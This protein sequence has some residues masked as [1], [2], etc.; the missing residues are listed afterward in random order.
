MSPSGT[1]AR[2]LRSSCDKCHQTK[3]KCIPGQTGCQRCTNLSLHCVYS[4]PGRSGRIPAAE[5]RARR[6]EK[7][8]ATPPNQSP[9][10][11][12]TAQRSSPS[13]RG[14]DTQQRSTPRPIVESDPMAKAT[15]FISGSDLDIL[16][17]SFDTDTMMDL[18]M[19]SS[20]DAFSP[21]TTAVMDFTMTTES[22]S[23]KPPPGP[24]FIPQKPVLNDTSVSQCG[25]FQ[26][27]IKALQDIQNPAICNYSLDAMLSCNK[28]ALVAICN[29]LKCPSSHD[30]TTRLTTLVVVQRV[31]HLYRI[32]YQSR[33]QD[34][35]HSNIH[36][37]LDSPYTASYSM[38]S[39]G[40]SYPA[41]PSIGQS[42]ESSSASTTSDSN[43]V[44][45]ASRNLRNGRLSLGTYK[46][47][48]ADEDSLTKQL[49]ILDL[50][51]IPRL[52]ERLDRR[53][54]GPDETDGLDLYNILRSALLTGFRS[55]LIEATAHR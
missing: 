8:I 49:L 33:L 45:P 1:G 44:S 6:N 51:K 22:I 35:N 16:L 40:S 31:L 55:L 20:F 5:R 14:R 11:D 19:P 41:P 12:E 47:D 7:G 27:I 3:L 42:T 54:Y 10:E 24:V 4:P 38:W 30:G 28:D 32:L 46:L 50:N 48:S 37:D 23:G 39:G 34:R 36:P 29:S 17:G 13:S 9:S 52:L 18:P 15:D 2:G 21:T 53:T 26:S 25:C 43:G